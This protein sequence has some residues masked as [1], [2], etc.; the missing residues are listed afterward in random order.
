M[1]IQVVQRWFPIVPASPVR[2]VHFSLNLP[3]KLTLC[4]VVELIFLG[5]Q[6][7]HVD[8]EEY[9]RNSGKNAHDAV[10]PY[11]ERIS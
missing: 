8:P 10:I 1:K 3:S 5:I 6:P 2:C 11:Q 7:A 9:R 4:Q